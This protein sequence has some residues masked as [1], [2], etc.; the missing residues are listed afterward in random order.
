MISTIEEAR[1]E[2]LQVAEQYAHYIRDIVDTENTEPESLDDCID[3][4]ERAIER[5]NKKPADLE[6]VTIPCDKIGREVFSKDRAQD[7]NIMVNLTRSTDKKKG[8]SAYALVSL[9]F[10]ALACMPGF[11]A[12]DYLTAYDRAVFIALNNIYLSGEHITSA[13]QVHRAM[14]NNGKPSQ[15][16]RK[17]ILR[18]V[19][20]LSAIRITID[21][22]QESA[23][24]NY[25]AVKISR[26]NLMYTKIECA[27]VGGV[28]TEDAIIIQELAKLFKMAI[29]RGQ[30]IPM[31]R[32]ALDI[33]I[34]KTE[35]N[36]LLNDYLRERVCSNFMAKNTKIAFT[37]LY[38]LME[39][40]SVTNKNTAK[41]KKRRTLENAEKLL[42]HY[43]KHGKIKSYRKNRD[44]F[45]FTR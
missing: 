29:D 39:I 34:D 25:D 6:S 31:S 7:K 1:E 21:N 16:Q 12:L 13:Y 30:I 11:E 32:A 3:I 36:L 14:G 45:S 37:K 8:V 42:Q 38:S 43:V 10:A 26:E 22:S 15:E 24:Y 9:D 18:A 20:K 41:S 28:L 4:L 27:I 19:D 33:P 5:A 35:N 17:K 2:F 40:E 23:F 44:H